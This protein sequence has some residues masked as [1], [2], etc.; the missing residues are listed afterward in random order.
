MTR[1]DIS[2]FRAARRLAVG[3]VATAAAV[4][5]WAPM[6]KA[7]PESEAADAISAAWQAAGGADSVVGS[8]DGDPYAVGGGYAQDFSEGKIFFTPDAGAHLLYGAVLDK[9]E[10][11]GGPADSDLGFPTLDE[12][13]GP[14]DRGVGGA[15]SDQRGLGRAGRFV[16]NDGCP[17][18]GRALRR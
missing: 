7:S 12:V 2:L 13:P 18:G 8:P 4:A 9:Y 5:L 16:G 14:R 6:A 3:V 11:L 15:W 10:S 1:V 17:G